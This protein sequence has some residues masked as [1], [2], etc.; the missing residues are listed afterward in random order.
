MSSIHGIDDV[1][2]LAQLIKSTLQ[3]LHTY[4]RGIIGGERNTSS[5]VN[6]YD[7]TKHEC[8]STILQNVATVQNIGTGGNTPIYLMGIQIRAALTGTL[9]IVGFT[10]P[11]G[12]PKNWVLPIGSVGQI[13]PPGNARRLENGCTMQL[14]AGADGDLVVVDW[15][16]IV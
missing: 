5:L 10:D 16:P 12:T 14:S 15:R 7:V 6:N 8:N 3:S 1:S 9:T 11:R 2:G 13:L 4:E